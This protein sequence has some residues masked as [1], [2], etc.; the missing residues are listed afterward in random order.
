AAHR[1]VAA[2][3]HPAVRADVHEALDVHRDLGAQR[4]LDAIELLDLLAELVHVRVRQVADALLGVHAGR[5]EDAP[6][7]DAPDAVDVSQADLDLLVAR[8]VHAGN[9]S[10]GRLTLP[11][12][13]LGIALADDPRDTRTLDH[14]AVLANRLDAAAN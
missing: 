8:K 4:T 11:L 10:H 1:E 13:V 9:T 12:L 2:V 7:E 14:L 5:F 3:P 6:G